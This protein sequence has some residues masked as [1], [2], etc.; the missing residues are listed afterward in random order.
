MP[1]S[2]AQCQQFNDF[3]GRRPYD[4]DKKI[5]KDRKPFNYLYTGM[6]RTETFPT[7]DGVTHLHEKVYVTRPNDPGLWSQ[8]SG[9][10]P[11]VGA[12][13]KTPRQYIGHGVDQLRY[14]RYKREYQTPVFCIDQLNTIEEGIQKMAAIAEGYKML[15]ENI[16]SD[17]LRLLTLRKAGTAAQG[18]GLF[19]C[20]VSD[21][22]G[23]PVAIDVDDTMFQ[24]NV[25]GGAAGTSNSLFM[26]LNALGGLSA[27][28]L[29]TTA[30]LAAA[31]GQ[32]TMEYLANQQE[33]L[34]ANGYHDREWLM[35]GKFSI[36]VDATTRRNLLAANPA[37]T[38]MYDAADF[39]KGGAFYSYGMTSG[40]GDW[41]FKEDKQQMRF[42]FRGDLDGK[43]LSGGVL[44]NSVWVE[45]VWPYEN[46][47]ATYGL[48]PQFSQLWKNAPIRL[49]HA[50]NRD[51]RNLFVGDITSV[52]DEM[53]FG[54][55]R[56]FMGRWTW[57]S[58]DYFEAMD[59]NTGVV[60]T[61]QNDKQNM[62]YWIGEY[63][64]AE[65]TVYPEIERLI[66][67]LGE[68]QPYV[69]RPNTNTPPSA[70]SSSSNYQSLLAYNSLCGEYTPP[71]FSLPIED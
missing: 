57:K 13:C 47:S 37:L 30:L 33:D 22:N 6:Y 35:D 16:C 7:F 31:M 14:D 26:N 3:L 32:L 70:P 49:Y 52:N 9:Y 23:N 53:K 1:L 2:T 8:I 24:V 60:C 27:L 20:G 61:Y 29:G 46:V 51:A 38:H 25:S 39:A 21:S 50:W 59:P 54:L 55:A 42:R 48:K 34:A 64:L 40:C 11:C 43:S 69:R 63:D 68:P 62:G 45:Q 58:P 44:A 56:S 12:P 15:P 41:L 17:F 4:W 5:A 36:T 67:A 65:K 66:F 28:G 18:A 71:A 19:L 10:D